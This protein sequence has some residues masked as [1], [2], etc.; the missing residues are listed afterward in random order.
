MLEGELFEEIFLRLEG[1]V[2]VLL[3]RDRFCHSG[4]VPVV[5]GLA[6]SFSISCIFPF[7]C[8]SGFS[9]SL[10]SFFYCVCNLGG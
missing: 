6:G 9:F 1:G 7:F 4:V 10:V 8:K 5:A 2:V 3:F